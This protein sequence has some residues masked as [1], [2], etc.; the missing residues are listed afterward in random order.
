MKSLIIE[1]TD[2]TPKVVLDPENG[3]FEI[4][5]KSIPTDAETFYGPILEWIE[6]YAKRPNNKTEIVLNLE[7]FNISSSKRILFL[8]YKLN[9]MIEKGYEVN[10]KWYYSEN[11]DEMYEVGQDYAFMVNVPF[12]FVDYESTMPQLV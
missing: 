1:S 3:L 8:L 5:G 9:E 10:I 6:G 2:K 4:I 12:E 11:D 7:F